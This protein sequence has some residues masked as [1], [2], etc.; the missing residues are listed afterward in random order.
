VKGK[1]AL[2]SH[3]TAQ[4]QHKICKSPKNLQASLTL[5]AV[6]LHMSARGTLKISD[7]FWASPKPFFLARPATTGL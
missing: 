6:H 5:L 7:D 1:N 4:Q 3:A 2:P